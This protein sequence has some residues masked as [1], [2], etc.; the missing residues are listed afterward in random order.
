[1]QSVNDE[2]SRS[3]S[4]NDTDHGIGCAEDVISSYEICSMAVDTTCCSVVALDQNMKPLRV[5]T[6]EE[7]IL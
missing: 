3:T 5:L 2:T 6:L 7:P 1:M 4:E